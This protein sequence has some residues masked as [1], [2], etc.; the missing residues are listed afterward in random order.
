[1]PGPAEDPQLEDQRLNVE[2][3]E[4]LARR[5]TRGRHMVVPYSDHMI[6]YHAP[7]AVIGAVRSVL[8]DCH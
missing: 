5:S 8:R 3:H 7:E 6:P 4:R 2:I 1:M